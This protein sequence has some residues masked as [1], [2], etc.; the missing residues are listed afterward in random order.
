M[1][2]TPNMNTTD[3]TLTAGAIQPVVQPVMA[4]PADLMGPPQVSTSVRGEIPK[5]FYTCRVKKAEDTVSASK[6]RMIRFDCETIAPDEQTTADGRVVKTAGKTFQIF[7]IIDPNSQAFTS[8]YEL[9]NKLLLLYPD[10]QFSPS[11]IVNECNRGM[12][13]FMTV[14]E[15]EPEYHRLP[16]VGNEKEGKIM[17]L[18][19]TN[20][21]M[22]RGYRIS[23]PSAED[24]VGR[25]QPPEGFVPPPF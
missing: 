21:P 17:C 9:L 7:A 23:L 1:T 2:G 3:P 13:F 12:I 22:L 24:I 11:A 16:K 20:T 14:L 6:L 19:G 8:G 4:A 5:N 15:G 10:G 25:V 18:P